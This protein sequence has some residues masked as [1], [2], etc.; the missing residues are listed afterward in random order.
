MGKILEVARK[1]LI[2]LYD[3]AD[4]RP[5]NDASDDYTNQVQSDS[6]ELIKK[7]LDL[8]EEKEKGVNPTSQK[9]ILFDDY[10]QPYE[11]TVYYCGKCV[12][13][14][15]HHFNYCPICGEKIL[16]GDTE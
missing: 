3:L 1:S 10:E 16:R 12:E 8:L 13:T 2:D 9:K 15:Y 11:E 6:Y 7:A 14:L 4:L 5:Q